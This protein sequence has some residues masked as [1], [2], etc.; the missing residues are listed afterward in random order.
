MMVS[1]RLEQLRR[2][3]RGLGLFAAIGLV[4]NARW[5]LSPDTRHWT[6]AHVLFRWF[7]VPAA[8]AVAVLSVV[9]RR[10]GTED[11]SVRVANVAAQAVFAL[12]L[13]F[14]LAFAVLSAIMY[15]A[16]GHGA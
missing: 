15:W 14:V 5:G 10:S 11:T 8:V 2:W 1:D 6:A 7:T 16:L 3:A 9:L 4:L 12:V 13:A